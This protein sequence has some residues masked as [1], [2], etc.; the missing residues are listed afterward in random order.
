MLTGELAFTAPTVLDLVSRMK[1][2]PTPPSHFE[3]S[4][5]R[6]LEEVILRCLE[7]DPSLRFQTAAECAEA[8]AVF[9]TASVRLALVSSP[10]RREAPSLDAAD[11]VSDA[12]LPSTL[13]PPPPD[14]SSDIQGPP[15][16]GQ[17]GTMRLSSA[18][19]REVT[20][21]AATREVAR[22]PSRRRWIGLALLAL[23]ALLGLVWALQGSA[24][25]E[26]V[27]RVRSFR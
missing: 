7:H 16:S 1:T 26:L 24:W 20:G 18:L 14:S 3:S 9:A 10:Q 22:A 11:P 5:P 25:A 13:P 8:L 17:G 6:D 2:P 19:L 23:V 15:P 4:I 27:A 21:P 12:E